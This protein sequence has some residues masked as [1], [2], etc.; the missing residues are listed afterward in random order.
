MVIIEKDVGKWRFT[1]CKSMT[2]E[3]IIVES[4]NIGTYQIAKRLGP[5]TLYNYF[6]QVA[7]LL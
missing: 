2:A 5:E 1:W 4:S 7:F 3:E 6:R